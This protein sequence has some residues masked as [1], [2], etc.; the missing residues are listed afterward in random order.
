V[1]KSLLYSIGP[2]GWSST[3]GLCRA[4]RV[5]ARGT[6]VVRRPLQPVYGRCGELDFEL[7]CDGIRSQ[8]STHTSRVSLARVSAQ[9]M[10]TIVDSVVDP[11]VRGTD[12]RTP[13]IAPDAR[14]HAATTADRAP[15]EW[16]VTV[17]QWRTTRL[18]PGC[19]APPPQRLC[20]RSLAPPPQRTPRPQRLCPGSLAPPPQRPPFFFLE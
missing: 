3:S 19:L 11:V 15:L 7:T 16:G 13:P 12:T 18:C 9:P 14:I 5:T 2:A 20:P 6:L 8:I 17:P 4:N 1:V 10:N